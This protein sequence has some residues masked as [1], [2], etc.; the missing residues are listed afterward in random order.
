[1]ALPFPSLGQRAGSM[2]R[3]TPVCRTPKHKTQPPP[4]R[5]K[6]RCGQRKETRIKPQHKTDIK[7]KETSEETYDPRESSRKGRLKRIYFN[8]LNQ[9]KWRRMRHNNTKRK[10]K[11]KQNQTKTNAARWTQNKSP[12]HVHSNICVCVRVACYL[13]FVSSREK[14]EENKNNHSTD[15]SSPNQNQTDETAGPEA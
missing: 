3:G 1:M 5:H 13:I 4:P 15:R 2:T 6:G 9:P 7:K 14:T 11:K 12:P 10:G 8:L